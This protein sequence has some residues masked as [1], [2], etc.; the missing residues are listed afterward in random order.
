MGPGHAEC[1]APETNRGEARR[2]RSYHDT[3]PDAGPGGDGGS[4]RFRITPWNAA[5]TRPLRGAAALRVHE[6]NH[7]KENA[8]RRHPR[9]RDPRRGGGRNPGRRV[10]L[11]VAE[12]AAA[13]RQH[14]SRQGH[15]G[16]AVAAGGLRRLRRQPPRL[17]RLLGNPPRLLPDPQGRPRGADRR[18]GRL[19]READEEAA[20]EKPKPRARSR[21]RRRAAGR[22]RGRPA[23][24][25]AVAASRPV[26]RGRGRRHGARGRAAALR[27]RRRHRR[28][29]CPRSPRRAEAR[30]RADDHDDGDADAR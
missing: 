29:T 5:S 13:R 10:R 30:G 17:P 9:G 3:G 1:P 27:R 25:D 26:D 24:E 14:L 12:Q 28:S 11:R 16:R 2:T 23:A 7:D 21:S 18:G 15:P 4:A 6:R 8:D 22:R 19:A 20:R